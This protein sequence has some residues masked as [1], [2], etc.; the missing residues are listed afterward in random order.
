MP[1][2][3]IETARTRCVSRPVRSVSLVSLQLGDVD[4]GTVSFS[5][6]NDGTISGRG[7][8]M[9]SGTTACLRVFAGAANVTK[10]GVITNSGTIT[11]EGGSAI[12]IEG[13]SYTGTITNSGSLAG[14][15][16]FDASAA[17]GAIDFANSGTLNGDF[18]GSSFADTLSP[19]DAST[20]AGS[21]ECHSHDSFVRTRLNF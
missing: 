7:K 19:Q 8:A 13:V 1:N 9:A 6:L 4:E 11:S 21:I 10:N 14:P 18:I 2:T 20:L 12:V 3:R 17:L 15:A 5:I 16:A